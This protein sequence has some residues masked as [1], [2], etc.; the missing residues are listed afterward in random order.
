MRV[1]FNSP[2]F[3]PFFR[4]LGNPSHRETFESSH[5]VMLSIFASDGDTIAS[6]ST[7]EKVNNDRKGKPVLKREQDLDLSTRIIPGYVK[8]LLEVC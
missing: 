3:P 5:S 4:H 7:R 8:S 6:A 1:F 2:S